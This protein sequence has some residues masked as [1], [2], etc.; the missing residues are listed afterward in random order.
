MPQPAASA[1]SE[2][3]FLPRDLDPVRPFVRAVA[4]SVIAA[5]SGPGN[6][7]A[8]VAT[9]A[10]G[11]H[12][13][14]QVTLALIQRAAS[15]PA[16][17]F[18]SG[19]AAE[20][21]ATSVG[22]FV[23]SLQESAAAR[24]IAA[25]PRLSL[26]GVAQLTLPRATSTGVA[27]WVLEGAAAPAASAVIGGPTL[28]PAK[29]LVLI[30]SYTRELG[31]ASPED[32]AAIIGQVLRDAITY[33]LDAS[34]F[35]NTAA[36]SL[37]P[38]GIVAGIA[39]LTAATGGGQQ[40]ALSDLRSLA[41]AVTAGGGGS[42]IAY[43]TSPGRA[44]AARAYVPG[45]TVWGSAHIPAGSIF[46]VSISAFVSAFGPDVELRSSLETT[47]HYD[48]V[49]LQLVDTGGTVATPARSAFQQDLVVV[50]AVLRAA[51]AL[52]VPA[53]AWISTGLTW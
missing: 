23:G 10:W 36:S 40:A 35:S 31:E 17:S 14:N 6:N 53:A 51:W 21:A 1:T 18:T 37:R 15:S 29:K 41:D 28:G 27:G 39:A 7:P 52:R 11:K 42:D 19:W 8:D 5:A 12:P 22:A 32:V 49:P 46:A 45:I 38:A 24:L 30:E 2:R 44:L 13:G 4:A 48:T 33:Q 50:R 43:V 3:P 25:A 20:L 34:V 26:A 16:T 47:I 9:R